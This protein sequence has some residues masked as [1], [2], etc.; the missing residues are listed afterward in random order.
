MLA[1]EAGNTLRVL[2]S[3]LPRRESPCYACHA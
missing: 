3:T 1:I 2:P